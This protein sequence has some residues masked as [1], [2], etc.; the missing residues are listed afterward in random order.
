MLR[1]DACIET[2]DGTSLNGDALRP[3]DGRLYPALLPGWT[4]R[5]SSFLGA[6]E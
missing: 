3:S 1:I 2:I 5:L 4:T 6:Q